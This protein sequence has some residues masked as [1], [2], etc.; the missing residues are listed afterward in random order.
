MSISLLC[1]PRCGDALDGTTLDGLC[2]RCMA[3]DFFGD[4]PEPEPAQHGVPLGDY[5]ILGEIGRGGMGVVYRARQTSLGRTVAVKMILA[6]MS[7]PEALARFKTEAAAAAGLRHP[8]IVAVYETGEES[9]MHFFSMDLIEGQ[10]LSAR[11]RDGPL[12]AREA[13]RLVEK[14]ALAVAYA[15][16]HAV[17]HRDLKPSNVL[18][19]ASGEPQVTDFGLAKRLG[20][21]DDLTLSGQILGSPGY[22][23]PE[24]ARGEGHKAGPLVDVYG[25]GAILYHALTGRA[26]FVGEDA[27][28][29]L[30]Q[31]ERNDPPSLRLLNPAVP[32][33][34]EAV[35]L[36]CVMREPERR[37]PS[38]AE[39]AAELRRWLEGKPVHAKP[40]TRLAKAARWMRRNPVIAVSTLAVFLALAAVALISSISARR[41]EKSRN[42]EAAQRARAESERIAAEKSAETLRLN[43]YAADMPQAQRFLAEGDLHKARLLLDAHRPKANQ[44]DARG[45]EWRWLWHQSQGDELASR[46]S[47]RNGVTDIAYSRDGTHFAMCSQRASVWDAGTLRMKA[48]SPPYSMSSVTFSRDGEVLFFGDVYGNVY[49]WRWGGNGPAVKIHAET[50]GFARVRASPAEDVIAVG[51]GTRQ[52][53]EPDG[54]MTLRQ[55]TTGELIRELPDAGGFA[56]FSPDGSLLATGASGG[57]VKLWDPRTGEMR[58]AFSGYSRVTCLQF[59]ADGRSL[60][61][62]RSSGP[63]RIISVETGEQ[64]DGA[65]GFASA[66]WGA[67]LSPDGS[68][69]ATAGISQAAALWDGTTGRELARFK[70]HLRGAGQVLWTPDGSKFMTGGADGTVKIWP[71]SPRVRVPEQLSGGLAKHPFS[72]EGRRLLMALPKGKT[73]VHAWPSLEQ[74]GEAAIGEPLGFLAT[75]EA[76][77]YVEPTE[78]PGSRFAQAWSVPGFQPGKKTQLAGASEETHRVSVPDPARWSWGVTARGDARAWD[79]ANG[80]RLVD[81]ARVAVQV[82]TAFV[83]CDPPMLALGCEVFPHLRVFSLLDGERKYILPHSGGSPSTVIAVDDGRAIITTNGSSIARKID[84]QTRTEAWSFSEH[85]G[86]VALSS[87]GRTLAIASSGSDSVVRLW[88]VPTRREVTRLNRPSRVIRMAFSPD[89]NALLI[90]QASGETLVLRATELAEA[91]APE[92]PPEVPSF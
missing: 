81:F 82:R 13:A 43:L 89:G 31:V 69:L 47:G 21:G 68:K 10:P 32:L 5:E 25:L 14:I 77:G 38:A 65:P 17:V 85:D 35:A 86:A 45:W 51:T 56:A 19:D 22:L 49:R 67:A 34:L 88:N 73:A 27:V 4:D 58:R 79:L 3:L 18:L 44:K 76:L 20:S 37:Y 91:D 84:L 33:E 53:G 48:A 72:T 16:E 71:A 28:A 92:P 42:E 78:S 30:R 36:K 46:Y 57:S 2:P 52:S 66:V 54:M 9:G 63:C 64:R 80:G 90:S 61:V 40:T 75:G 50:Q 23:A 70:G 62:S 11:L 60:V 15:H 59:S 74:E 41:L 8:N 26:P 24:Q 29:V 83:L 7:T 1:C 12:P 6:G 55:A 87:D 39:V